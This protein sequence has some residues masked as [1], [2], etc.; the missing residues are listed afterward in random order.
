MCTNHNP[1]P[2][3][4]NIQSD[5]SSNTTPLTV[6]DIESMF[7]SVVPSHAE[8]LRSAADQVPN[9]PEVFFER[10]SRCFKGFKLCLKCGLSGCR[11]SLRRC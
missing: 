8:Y 7:E 9:G 3:D 5:P 10:C 11:V 4:Q 2:S 6:D 1:K